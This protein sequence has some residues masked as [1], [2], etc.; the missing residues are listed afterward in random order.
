MPVTVDYYLSLVSP[1]TFL[2]D[3][4]IREIAGRHG[5]TLRHRPVKLGEVFAETGGLPLGRRAPARR[6]Y[7]LQELQRWS[8]HLDIHL[9]FEPA[10]FPADDSEAACLVI[11]AQRAGLEVGVLAHAIL[12]AV[13]QEE[14]NI[15]E[16]TTLIDLADENGYPGEELIERTSD[17]AITAEYDEN[18]QD[19][20]RTGVFGA[21][22]YVVGEQL[23]WG[24][25]RLDFVDRQLA[26][27]VG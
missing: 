27:L 25:D 6:A 22:S 23:F 3:A 7:R 26:R 15:A 4:R 12:R 20:I 9:N 14:R 13:W 18:T 1:W 17:E 8:D 5:A 2:G 24:Q 21:P 10:F 19:A 16:P 11:A